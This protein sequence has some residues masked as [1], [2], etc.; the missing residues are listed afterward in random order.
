MTCSDL[1]SEKT[2]RAAE[3][4]TDGMRFALIWQDQLGP[5]HYVGAL[6]EI[7]EVDQ[8]D[9]LDTYEVRLGGLEV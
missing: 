4:E 2:T 1:P 9:R 3:F 5:F 8:F 6:V 7:G